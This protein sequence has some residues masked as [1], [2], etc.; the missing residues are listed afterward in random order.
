MTEQPTYKIALIALGSNLPS[1]AGLPAITL[2]Q[3][4]LRM[5]N[6]RNS[7]LLAISRFYT[8]PAIPL[9]A[10]PDY[11]NA[12]VALRTARAPHDLLADLH[13]IEQEFGRTRDGRRWQSRPVDLDLLA[14]DDM[15]LPDAPTQSDWRALTREEQLK[16]APDRLILP[17]P[18]LQERGFVLVPLAEIAPSWRHPLTGNSVARMLAA[19]PDDETS[20]IRPIMA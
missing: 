18:R 15:V 19:L 10:G 8:T 11:V 4:I 7:S 5:H 20:A 16:R 2:G 6:L 14:M 3:C 12:A 1:W 13:A 17:H 9:G